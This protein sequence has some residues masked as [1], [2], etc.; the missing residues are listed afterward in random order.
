MD[1]SLLKIPSHSLTREFRLIKHGDE[2]IESGEVFLSNDHGVMVL[3]R[4]TGV[5]L[6]KLVN[7]NEGFGEDDGWGLHLL[8]NHVL[9]V[10][11]LVNTLVN[12]E[13]GWSI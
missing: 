10:I 4:G 13:L 5:I 1:N 3:I 11:P 8:H 2:M 9:D 12:K 6:L 7:L